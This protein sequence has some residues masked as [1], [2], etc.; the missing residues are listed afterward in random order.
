MLSVSKIAVVMCVALISA[1]MAAA[2]P[3][4]SSTS[5]SCSSTTQSPSTSSRTEASAAQLSSSRLGNLT[6]KL[7]GKRS[8]S[9]C[10]KSQIGEP[11]YAKFTVKFRIR[12]TGN[13]TVRLSRLK[14]QVSRG[15][16]P[17]V[18]LIL[19]ERH[20][21]V[22]IPGVSYIRKPPCIGRRGATEARI[23]CKLRKPK[24]L[25]PGKAIKLKAPVSANAAATG[26]YIKVAVAGPPGARESSLRDNK[27]R[28][29]LKVL[30]AD[31]SAPT[32]PSPRR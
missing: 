32:E 28:I 21:S 11:P 20:L 16:K 2:G 8:R 14:V 6:V 1:L 5:T 27:A 17:S 24:V 30:S 26:Q 18:L 23:N 31:G 3:A 22:G 9:A 29:K 4:D 15:M 13:R 10:I 12:N 25:K 7:I 19:G